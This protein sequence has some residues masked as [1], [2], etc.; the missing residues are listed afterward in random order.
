MGKSIGKIKPSEDDRKE[1]VNNG[2]K[3]LYGFIKI[4]EDSG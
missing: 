2:I 3:R 1:E 4:A